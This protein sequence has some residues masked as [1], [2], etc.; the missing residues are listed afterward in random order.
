LQ[1]ADFRLQILKTAGLH[2]PRLFKSKIGNL[3]SA[4][5]RRDPMAHLLQVGAGSGGMP[6]LDL[7]CRDAR[8][9]RVTLIDPDVYKP[10]N[11]ERHLF[12]PS[13]VGER[14]AVLAE[15]WLKERRPEMDV[16]ILA[17]DLIEPA[18]QHDIEQAAAEADIG[19]C[20]ADNEP[21]KFHFDALMRRHELP[22]TLGE[23]LSGG[24][25]GFVHWFVP[26]GPCYGCVASYLKRSVAEE[27]PVKAPDYSQ[28]GGPVVATTIPA[29]KAAIQTIA[30][31]HALVTLGLLANPTGY[32]PGFSSLLL[33]LEKVDQ[34]FDEAFRPYRFRIPRA[35]D[36]L[37]CRAAATA[38]SPED[39]D[40]ALD[41]ALARLGNA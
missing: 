5:P 13:T 12:P 14:K 1:I 24:I 15:R 26:G 23:V 21:A 22:W 34:V 19:I 16:R 11:V 3:K 41:Q 10:H 39:L 28:P 36:C 8:V 30:S 31:L 33:S 6:V 18:A 4:I 37:I 35:A 32:Q 40:V 7:V 25:G 2:G 17:C 20:A 29:S 9:T 27:K 38:S